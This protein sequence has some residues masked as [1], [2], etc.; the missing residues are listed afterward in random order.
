MLYVSQASQVRKVTHLCEAWE[1]K[2]IGR[3]KALG[4]LVSYPMAHEY[5]IVSLS[6]AD[7]FELRTSWTVANKDQFWFGRDVWIGSK[8]EMEVLFP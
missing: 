3:S 2:D 4:Q 1:S 6:L 7:V 8:E 5:R